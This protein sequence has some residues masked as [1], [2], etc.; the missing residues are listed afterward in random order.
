MTKPELRLPPDELRRHLRELI[1]LLDIHEIMDLGKDAW[2]RLY[3][4]LAR[5][6]LDLDVDEQ[7]L[8]SRQTE[9]F[10]A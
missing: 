6:Q 2:D 5:L 9:L 3:L 7:L 10:T 4:R 8:R 1:E